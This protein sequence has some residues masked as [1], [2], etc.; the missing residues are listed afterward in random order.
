MRQ[1]LFIAI[2]LVLFL[3]SAGDMWAVTPKPPGNICFEMLASS[4]PLIGSM[5]LGVKSA[6]TVT[7]GNGPTNF[8]ALNGWTVLEASVVGAVLLSGT[9][10]MDQDANG[11]FHFSVRGV[12]V[13]SL[14]ELLMIHLEGYWNIITKTGNGSARLSS[15]D[16]HSTNPNLDDESYTFNF[17]E[18]PCGN[19]P[20][21]SAILNP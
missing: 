18:R 5:A 8:Y 14:N 20:K 6:A 16:L 12:G 1:I 3:F 15:K 17:L 10:H 4:P 21:P 11:L 13:D 19:F 7:L 2:G 9:G